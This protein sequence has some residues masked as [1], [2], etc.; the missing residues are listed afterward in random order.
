M[1]QRR[2]FAVA[3]C[4]AAAALATAP[5]KASDTPATGT[6]TMTT[7]PG[8]LPAWNAADVTIVGIAPGT[9]TTGRFG[10]DATVTLPVVARNGTATATAGGFRIVNTDSGASVRCII[11][12]IDTRARV[13]DCLTT[14]G[15]NAALFAIEDIEGRQNFTTPSRRS[16][17]VQGM[18]IRLTPSGV[19]TLNRAL[20]VRAF[21][22]S[23]RFADGNLFAS[24]AR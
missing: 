20:G 3:T 9:V 15:Y 7:A 14:A 23:V 24:Q 17:L 13:I 6:F 11:P 16:T 22:T 21:S 12:A 8:I 18:E 1:I 2:I 5:V 19:A 10:N 4:L